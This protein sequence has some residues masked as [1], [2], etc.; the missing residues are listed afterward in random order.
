MFGIGCTIFQAA[1][2][3]R[4]SESVS[5]LFLSQCY[6]RYT[7]NLWS[8]LCS[9]NLTAGIEDSGR[10]GRFSDSLTEQTW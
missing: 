6:G 10:Q 4:A 5:S 1:A 7:V 8:L 3:A 9:C 2:D